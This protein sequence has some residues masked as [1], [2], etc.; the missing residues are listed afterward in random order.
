MSGVGGLFIFQ[1]F[2]TEVGEKGGGGLVA[3]E[4][5]LCLGK[6][7]ARKG[8]SP[9]DQRPVHRLEGWGTVVHQKGVLMNFHVHLLSLTISKNLRKQKRLWAQELNNCVFGSD[10]DQ[11]LCMIH[12]KRTFINI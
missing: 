11:F 12:Q 3:C 10:N 2:Y 9:L 1:C 6:K 8:N 4:Q 5:A 7:I